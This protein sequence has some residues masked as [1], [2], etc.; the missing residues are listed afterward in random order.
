[1]AGSK[2]ILVACLVAWLVAWLGGSSG[3]LRSGSLRT[4]SSRS[5]SLRNRSL[6]T[7]LSFC[8]GVFYLGVLSVAVL[9][10]TPAGAQ[11]ALG[12]SQDKITITTNFSGT[13]LL[14][15]GATEEAGDHLLVEVRGPTS[16][17][18]LFLRQRLAGFWLTTGRRVFSSVPGYYAL[19]ANAP[20]AEIAEPQLLR[21]LQLGTDNLVFTKASHSDGADG[22]DG[23]SGTE[24]PD[25]NTATNTTTNTAINSV[26]NNE[27]VIQQT[28]TPETLWRKALVRRLR[29]EG[30]YPPP[31]PIAF[32]EA[33]LFQVRFPIP[34]TAREGIYE[35]QVHTLREGVVQYSSSLHFR[36]EK[37]GFEAGLV[38]MAYNE[39]FLYAL[40]GLLLSLSLGLVGYL[41]GGRR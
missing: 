4:C 8:A 34:A 13:D 16:E 36:V 9:A 21:L 19:A 5:N 32:S 17:R 10:P 14:L 27:R 20:L 31:L 23:A 3:F 26:T 18:A 25:T 28:V 15:F 7:C 12:L 22:A 24:A 1:M 37:G 33:R 6:R 11:T 39:P 40:L 2:Q 41:L 29:A 35:V 38:H 30:H